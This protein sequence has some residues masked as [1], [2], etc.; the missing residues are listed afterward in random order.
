MIMYYIATAEN[1]LS[2][3]DDRVVWVSNGRGRRND[4]TLM[5]HS[6]QTL[7]ADNNLRVKRNVMALAGSIVSPGGQLL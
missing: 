5:P 2:T 1:G 6:G 3:L 4:G 7:R